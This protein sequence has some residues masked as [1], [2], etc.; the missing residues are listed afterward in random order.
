MKTR[1]LFFLKR[2][3]N[4]GWWLGMSG[5]G[6][7]WHLPL[8]FYAQNLVFK[9]NLG[10]LSPWKFLYITT[11]TNTIL[12]M[13]AVSQPCKCFQSMTPNADWSHPVHVRIHSS[14]LLESMSAPYSRCWINEARMCVCVCVELQKYS[15]GVTWLL[16]EQWSHKN[17]T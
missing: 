9:L 15:L 14:A 10:N 4:I 1:L 11:T 13:Y 12:C 3:L 7:Q 16:Q 17:K 2:H 6:L 8:N 5:C